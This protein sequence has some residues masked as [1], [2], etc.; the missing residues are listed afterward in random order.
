MIDI[1]SITGGIEIGKG[2]LSVLEFVSNLADSSVVSGY[3]RY[4][5][6]RVEGSEK[7][8]IELHPQHDDPAVWWF[9][10]KPVPEYVFVRIPIV[11]SCAHEQVGTVVGQRQPDALYW[12][13]IA[14]VLPGRVYGGEAPPNLKVDFLVFGYRPKA[15]IKHFTSK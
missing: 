10:V 5:G 12:R 3:F 14:P 1:S 13:W 15:L 6:T 2:I 7:I 9:S 11:E 8:E 4:D